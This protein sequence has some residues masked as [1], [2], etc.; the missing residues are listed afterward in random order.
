MAHPATQSAQLTAATGTRCAQ[1]CTHLQVF[2][3][4]GFFGAD[5]FRNV[6]NCA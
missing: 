2:E 1:F 3:N 6:S 5:L 4:T